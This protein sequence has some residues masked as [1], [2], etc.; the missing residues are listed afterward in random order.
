MTQK[1]YRWQ[2][3]ARATAL[4]MSV[5]SNQTNLPMSQTQEDPEETTWIQSLLSPSRT[6]RPYCQEGERKHLR[7]WAFNQKEVNDSKDI[8]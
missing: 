1:S 2:Q 5:K 6:Q 8:I 3:R 4:A 7:A